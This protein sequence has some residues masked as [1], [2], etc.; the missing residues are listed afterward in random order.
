[1]NPN[2]T[3][4]KHRITD[5]PNSRAA[6]REQGL[7]AY[8][9]GKPCPHGHVSVRYVA[10]GTCAECQSVWMK[11]RYEAGWRQSKK[12]RET[13][14]ARWNASPKGISAKLKWRRKD[15]KRTWCVVSAAHIRL[16]AK[17][18]G[19]PFDIDHEYLLSITPDECPIFGTKFSFINNKIPR[20]ESP[21]VDR[22]VSSLGYIKGNVVVISMKA[23]AI[24][25]AYSS[26]D[27]TRV[28]EWMRGRG[29]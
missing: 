22:L 23:N 15:P 10:A 13:I 20:P 5:L 14:N 8:F 27:V 6:A 2:H 19:I 1:M 18:S 3:N 29:L 7:R 11:K 21:S 28:G 25:S 26:S 17:A 4:A 16:R 9:T 24:K 12:G